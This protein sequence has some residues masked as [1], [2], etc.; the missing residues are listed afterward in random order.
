MGGSSRLGH[1]DRLGGVEREWREKGAA[2]KRKDERGEADRR[3]ISVSNVFRWMAARQVVLI[4]H[5][6][7]GSMPLVGLQGGRVEE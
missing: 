5:C 7:C 1:L 3:E 6:H 2:E 4:S